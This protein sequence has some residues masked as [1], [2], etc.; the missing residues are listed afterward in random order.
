MQ[1]KGILMLCQRQCQLSPLQAAA[2][3]GVRQTAW[4]ATWWS[5]LNVRTNKLQRRTQGAW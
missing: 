4:L 2:D 1:L 3:A 5:L